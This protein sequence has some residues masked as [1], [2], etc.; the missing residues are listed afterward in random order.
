MLGSNAVGISKLRLKQHGFLALSFPMLG[1]NPL[2]RDACT[3]NLL[4]SCQLLLAI[5]CLYVLL[6][7]TLLFDALAFCMRDLW[8]L[9]SNV[10]LLRIDARSRSPL[11]C[12]VRL[13][14]LPEHCHAFR[15]SIQKRTEEV[16]GVT[17]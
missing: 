6:L 2:L 8:M 9:C 15:S 3:L 10:L 12:V 11:L 7:K 4:S 13:D 16:S 5:C 17:H 14:L 1:F